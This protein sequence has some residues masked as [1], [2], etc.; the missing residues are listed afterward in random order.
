MIMATRVGDMGTLRFLLAVAVA[1]AHSGCFS[2]NFCL[3]RGDLA[4]QIFY[5]ISGFLIA[6][7]LH[8]KYDRTQ[9]WLFYSN[10]ALRIYVPYLFVWAI[11]LAG[12]VPIVHV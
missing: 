5:I 4:V 7:I 11:C 3:M 2:G 6:L 12:I 10:R 8:E 9:T 1:T